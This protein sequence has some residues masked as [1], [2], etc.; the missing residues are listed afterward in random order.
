MVF[1]SL[2]FCNFYN[3]F[4]VFFFIIFF[5][6]FLFDVF[7]FFLSISNFLIFPFSHFVPFSHFRISFHF[8]P[9]SSCFPKKSYLVPATSPESNLML[10]PALTCTSIHF[11]LSLLSR[12]TVLSIS[13]IRYT[14]PQTSLNTIL[15]SPLYPLKLSLSNR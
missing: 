10:I 3:F 14:S 5:Y 11:R 9:F 15:R 8:V 1:F 13:P 6:N 7:L 12:H 2:N 4:D